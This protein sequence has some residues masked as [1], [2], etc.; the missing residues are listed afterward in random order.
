MIKSA[1]NYHLLKQI[2]SDIKN[3]TSELPTLVEALVVTGVD[4]QVTAL[5][6]KSK[7]ESFHYRGCYQLNKGAHTQH[8]DSS[9]YRSTPEALIELAYQDFNNWLKIRRSD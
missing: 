7:N 2:E 9:S 4:I 8:G 3:K 6:R 1:P 5:I